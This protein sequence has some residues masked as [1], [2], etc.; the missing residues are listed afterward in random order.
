[1]AGQRLLYVKVR[2]GFEFI[3]G[4]SNDDSDENLLVPSFSSVRSGDK[5]D[6][7]NLSV[8]QG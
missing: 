6:E 2:E 7:T 4:E 1:M 5:N 3:Y 8:R